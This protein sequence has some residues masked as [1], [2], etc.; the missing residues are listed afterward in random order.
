MKP[1][2]LSALLCALAGD[3]F[4][5]E[6]RFSD[7]FTSGKDGYKSIRIPSAVVTKQGDRKS[8]V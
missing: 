1:L 5:A 6:P 7:V 3:V 8:V 2:L 4:A